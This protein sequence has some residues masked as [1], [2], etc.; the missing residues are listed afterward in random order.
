MKMARFLTVM[1][2]VGI[3]LLFLGSCGQ[4][5]T[6][7]NREEPT[8]APSP[9]PRPT[10]TLSPEPG[11]PDPIIT[12]SVSLEGGSCCAGGTM[13]QT[14]TIHADLT[15]HSEFSKVEEMRV[16]QTSSCQPPT[17]RELKRAA[18][19]PYAESKTFSYDVPI[20]WTGF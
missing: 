19:E 14:I 8:L 16:G 12:G 11:P 3:A 5:V 20:N 13:G 1:I 18:W 10:I 17:D 7:F 9:A 15:A 6:A 2:C 4:R